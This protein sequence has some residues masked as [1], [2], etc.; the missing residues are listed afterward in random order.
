MHRPWRGLAS[1][2]ALC[3]ALWFCPRPSAAQTPA[4][5]PDAL[6]AG[7]QILVLLRL[8]PPHY[9][10]GGAYGDSY[11]DTLGHG[12]RRRL[13]ERLARD[14]GLRV[15]TDWPMPLL[16][17]DCYVLAAPD[18]QDLNGEIAR[19]SQDP[20]VAWS[21][22][23]HVY[24]GQGARVAAHPSAPNDPLYAAQPAA[25]LWRLT[26]LHQMATGRGVLVA[27]VDSQVQRDHPDLAGQIG[28]AQSFVSGPPVEGESHGT[29]VAGV[30]AAR[31]NNGLGIAGVAPGARLMALRACWQT[32]TGSSATLCDSLTLAEALHFAVEHGARVINLS[33]G[34][35]PDELLGRLIDVA[36]A[37]GIA[38]VAAYDHD[39]PGG[40]FPAMHPGVVAV[41]DAPVAGASTALYTAPGRDIPT[42]QPG[43]RWSLVNGSSFAAAHVSGLIALTLDAR[44]EAAAPARAHGRILV[45]ARSGG[46]AIDACATLLHAQ[47]P[48]DCACAR[49]AARTFVSGP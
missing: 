17:V 38:V 41:S 8:P 49:P 5:A 15:V 24:R 34:G 22:P 32:G 27:L 47:G 7:H 30:I 40:G 42:T 3:L 21:Q 1:G 46:G 13:A 26:D 23:M 39:L 2:L 35:P 37:R 45:A 6:A 48:C 12:T 43:G 33:L 9:R 16:G 10:P 29:G 18:G 25:S 31:A 14:H 20:R 44:G 28:I 11:D 19:L 4:S 36:L